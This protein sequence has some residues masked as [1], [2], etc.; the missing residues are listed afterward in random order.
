MVEDDVTAVTNLSKV[1]DATPA[2]GVSE[3]VDGGGVEL[4]V[5]GLDEDGAPRPVVHQRV[6]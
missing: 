5:I 4:L 1:E 3:A 6:V 2:V